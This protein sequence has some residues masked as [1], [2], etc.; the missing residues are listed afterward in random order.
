M[1]AVAGGRLVIHGGYC[2][3]QHLGD[4]WVLD[5]A[6]WRWQKL[7]EQVGRGS[8]PVP[9]MLHHLVRC[10][11]SEHDDAV[12]WAL[13]LGA[14]VCA[15]WLAVVLVCVACFFCRCVLS[16]TRAR[17]G[18]C[19]PLLDTSAV[20]LAACRG[21]HPARAEATLQQWSAIATCCCMA[22]LMAR[23][24]WGMP[25]CWTS[26]AAPGPG[27]S[28]WLALS[29]CP[30]PEPSTA[31]PGWAMQRCCWEA[32]V[33]LGMAAVGGAHVLPCCVQPAAYPGPVNWQQHSDVPWH[34]I[35]AAPA[36]S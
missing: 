31:W 18:H 8:A 1:A 27:W 25:L 17:R 35:H 7:Q 30:L 12:G 2:D 10:H 22:A 20:D 5:T 3:E 16:H 28:W 32:Q 24:T 13:A 26:A 34:V 14:I 33:R 11:S 21:W 4:T 19:M 6:S 29:R 15:C 9:C 36:A 23:G